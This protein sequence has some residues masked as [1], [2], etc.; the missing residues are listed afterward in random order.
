MQKYIA[1]MFAE[2]FLESRGSPNE[3]ITNQRVQMAVQK[4]KF[5]ISMY[6]FHPNKG[7]T[8]ADSDG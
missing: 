6:S 4:S 5:V 3:A 8:G 2:S 7:K 1:D